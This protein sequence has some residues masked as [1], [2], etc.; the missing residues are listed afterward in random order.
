ML[1]S[2][3]SGSLYL[4]LATL[5]FGLALCS[6]FTYAQVPNKDALQIVAQGQPHDV[7]YGMDFEGGNGIAV[8]AFGV[9]LTSADGGNTWQKTEKQVTQSALFSV[10][11]KSDQC[12]ASGQMGLIL[13]S[14]D[15]KTWEVVKPVSDARLLSID[16][17]QQGKAVAVGG[18][19]AILVSLNWGKTW[20][21]VDAPWKSIL[22][23]NAEPH[24]YAAHINDAGI[25]TIAGE[26]G[27][28][29]QSVDGGKNWKTLHKG[30]HSLFGMQ[31]TN[32]GQMYAV[33][34]QGVIIKSTNNGG[35]WSLIK[36][37]S[38]SLLTGIWVSRDTKTVVI[39]GMRTLLQSNN[40]GT[41]FKAD[42]SM[43][44]SQSVLT[45]VTGHESDNKKSIV[46]ISGP[47]GQILKEVY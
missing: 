22:G 18:F 3:F 11:R 17:N 40:G 47:A 33:G 44:V 20:S 27:L 2:S 16:V 26:F 23:Q 45:A 19:G 42:T 38:K 13:R 7:I 39:T 1:A 8:G 30:E 14:S 34:Q 31:I 29:I 15:C 4:R 25:I 37:E 41:N 28:V 43:L 32:D 35:S 12:L 24:L 5:T 36:T 10:V 21:V 46:L 6:A 9:M